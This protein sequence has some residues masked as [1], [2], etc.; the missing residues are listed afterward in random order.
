[1]ILKKEKIMKPYPVL[2]TLFR[3]HLWSNLQLLNLCK[4]LNAEQLQ[5]SIVGVYGTLGDTLQHLVKA[6][7][8]YF[9]RVSTGQ[10]FRPPENEGDLTFEQMEA[11]LRHTGEGFIEWAPKVGAEETVEIQWN[12]NAV[13]GPVQVPKAVVLTQVINHATEHRTQILAMLTQLGIQPPELGSWDYFEAEELL[14]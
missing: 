5:T 13:Q 1:V 14:T 3:H 4:T 9:S 2:E 7:R 8:S 10:P 11:S 12:N 6:E